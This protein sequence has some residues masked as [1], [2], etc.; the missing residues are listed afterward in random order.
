M[1]KGIRLIFILCLLFLCDASSLHAKSTK[2]K[3]TTPPTTNVS[4]TT[5]L[6]QRMDGIEA[7]QKTFIAELKSELAS[8]KKEIETIKNLKCVSELASIRNEVDDI[9]KQK[10]VVENDL[11]GKYEEQQRGLAD[12]KELQQIL[13]KYGNNPDGMS[14]LHYAIKKGDLNAVSQ[15]IEN[16]ADVN[17]VT[18][19]FAPQTCVTALSRAAQ[20]NQ[21]EIAQILIN[22]DAD[23]N[24]AGNEDGFYPIHY[25]AKSGSGHLM[26]LLIENGAALDRVSPKKCQSPQAPLHIAVKAGNYETVVTLV[27]AG[28]DI[29][30]DSECI[31]G[32]PLDAAGR[33]L[34][35]LDNP[36][37]LEL[38]KF[39]VKNGAIRR[40][41]NY[42]AEDGYN[43]DFCPVISGYLKSLGK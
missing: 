6:T 30:A 32:T 39:L 24:F 12:S 16:G 17:S 23:V 14:A 2:K 11:M 18:M 42:Y 13:I 9:K 27:E 7:Q 33:Y 31:P 21:F 36:K 10:C 29:N 22:N 5:A 41:R 34:K 35:Y 43:N 38:V 15:L 1:I 4:V 37:N 8:M 3:T 40:T 19:D 20:F 25:A 28:A 26:L